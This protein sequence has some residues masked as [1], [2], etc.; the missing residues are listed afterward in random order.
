M[1]RRTVWGWIAFFTGVLALAFFVLFII[2]QA[3]EAYGEE[4]VLVD[5]FI[6]VFLFFLIFFIVA[7]SKY[8]A[9]VKLDRATRVFSDGVTTTINDGN[10]VT[11]ITSDN[12]TTVVNQTEILVVPVSKIK[13]RFCSKKYRATEPRCPL[14]GACHYDPA[15]HDPINYDHL[16]HDSKG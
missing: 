16:E 7:A 8:T 14:C 10:T 6:G 9:H 5:A 13:C 12:S 2:F 11:T 15:E 3:Q 1:R 4:T